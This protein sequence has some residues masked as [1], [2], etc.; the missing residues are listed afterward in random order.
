MAYMLAFQLPGFGEWILIALLGL[1]FFGKRLPEVGRSVGR[2]IVE[3]KKGLKEIETEVEDA[4]T[5]KNEPPPSTTAQARF[6]PITGK[7]LPGPEHKF[8]PYTGE[9]LAEKET[10][11]GGSSSAR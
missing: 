7:P 10:V 2:S 3:F 8:D 6:D 11:G 9:P 4:A 5:S 1:L